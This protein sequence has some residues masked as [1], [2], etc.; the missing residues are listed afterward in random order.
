M[1]PLTL[2]EILQ[3]IR[4]RPLNGLGPCSIAGVCTDSRRIQ[5]GEA[6]FAIRGERFDG[7]DFV[8]QALEQGAFCAVISDVRP[9][10]DQPCRN[11]LIRVDD[12]IKA[13]GRLASYHRR[14][15]PAVVIAVTG[16]NG[17]TTTKSM[18]A[19][20]LAATKKGRGAPGSFNN[21]IG[22]PLTLLSAEVG[23]EFLVVEIGS[24]S[25]GEIAQLGSLV[26]PD[27]A[28][29]TSVGPAHLEGLGDIQGVMAEKL[30][31]LDH[32]A[33]G[34]M[35]VIN[36]DEP[37]VRVRLRGAHPF[38]LVTFGRWSEAALRATDIR[39][40]S[41]SLNF[42][43]ND[44]LAVHM[45]VPGSHN[46]C[47]AL[48][49][50]A[51]AARLGLPENVIAER[52]GTFRL[53]EMRLQ[54]HQYGSLLVINDC[55][56]ANPASMRCAVD[57]IQEMPVPGRRIAIVGDMREL[58]PQTLALHEELGRTIAASNIDVLVSVGEF[59]HVVCD[60]A[61]TAGSR[62]LAVHAARSVAELSEG[63]N[64][65]LKP[66]D[67]VLLKGSR[68]MHMESLLAGIATR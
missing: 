24:N 52:L 49:A 35:A 23:D 28:V 38:N 66:K 14:Q 18:I 27:I 53:P 57:V 20:L 34:G 10:A 43:I 47:N 22:V 33:A 60:A 67:T 37:L 29:V 32:V 46:A 13:L 21:H 8:P 40:N 45:S 26:R 58:G 41:K 5:P 7:H 6:F 54:M 50:Y 30:S 51:V 68:A 9:F 63:I 61:R 3:A 42:K 2:N 11:R 36:V 31:L 12:T 4:G 64:S 39:Q 59:A 16:S 15:L 56:N 62:R 19:H 48:A 55:Y 65:L 1:I 44:R 25:P 17:K